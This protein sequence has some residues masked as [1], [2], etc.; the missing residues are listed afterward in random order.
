MNIL[1]TFPIFRMAMLQTFLC[2]MNMF[3]QLTQKLLYNNTTVIQ[4]KYSINAISHTVFNSY[5]SD[6]KHITAPERPFR[7][8]RYFVNLHNLMI[9]KQ[10]VIHRNVSFNESDLH[11]SYT[12]DVFR[13][14]KNYA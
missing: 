6:C 5:Y 13:F 12:A 8:L 10:V 11:I 4:I 14:Q 3:N 1:C 2:L 9:A 7:Q